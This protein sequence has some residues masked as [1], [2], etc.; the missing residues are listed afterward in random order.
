MLLF[1]KPALAVP[2]GATTPVPLEWGAVPD[3]APVPEGLAPPLPPL[4]L[5]RGKGAK[6]VEEV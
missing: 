2:V 5:G 4:W 3:G 6:P 1:L